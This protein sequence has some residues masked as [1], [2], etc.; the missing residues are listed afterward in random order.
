MARQPRVEFAGACYHIMARG[1][2]R[3]YVFRDESIKVLL[4]NT[5]GEVAVRFGWKIHAYA[6]MDNHYHILL[7][8]PQPNLVA[9]MSWLQTAFTVRCNRQTNQCGHVL[10]DGIKASLSRHRPGTT[11]RNWPTTFI[12]IRR[13]RTSFPCRSP[14]FSTLIGGQASIGSQN[15]RQTGPYGTRRKKF[16][17]AYPLGI[18]KKKEP[19]TSDSWKKQRETK[20]GE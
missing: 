8:T 19:V 10:R 6:I 3:E 9:G 12:L 5:L 2:R 20:R 16:S 14:T 4:I 17:C 18:M 11:S 15:R 7:E 1:N 13:V